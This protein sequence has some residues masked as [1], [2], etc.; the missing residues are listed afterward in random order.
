MT[1][2]V[3]ASVDLPGVPPEQ[4]FA[5]MVD[6]GAQERWMIATRLYEVQSTVPVPQVGS[7]AAAFTGVGGLGLL[8]TMQ[9][10]VYDPPHR[11]EVAKDGGLLRGVGTMLVEPIAGGCRASWINEL[12]PPFG[13]LGRLG[14]LAVRPIAAA[15]LQA[16]LRRLA[17]DLGTGA[18][19]AAAGRE[20]RR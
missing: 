12:T 17:R 10:T 4:A 2:V 8:D 19:P 1:A 20:V 13:V 5:A 11:W 16:C 14:F 9:V 18:L 3:R 15:A 6:L 7:R